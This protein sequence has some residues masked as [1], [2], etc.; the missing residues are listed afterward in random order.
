VMS[1]QHRPLPGGDRRDA[2]FRRS[3][4]RQARLNPARDRGLPFRE[5]QL[6]WIRA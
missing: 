5:Y 3:P 6:R 2:D 4:E 1:H